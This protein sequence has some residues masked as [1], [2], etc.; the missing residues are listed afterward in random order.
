MK[1][2]VKASTGTQAVE[3]S[4]EQRLLVCRH[5]DGD[6]V[7]FIDRNGKLTLTVIVSE[8]GTVLRFEGASVAVQASGELSIEAERLSL[9]G[10][11]GT[12]ITSGGELTLQASGDLHS[13]ARCQSVVATLGDVR[14]Q[15]ND[16][17]KL[18]GERVRMNC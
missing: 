17:V 7:Q 1:T 8:H 4:G 15:A 14:L 11:S 6:R 3:L 10:R 18:S 2:L 9:H 12:A 5:D 13:T 16:D